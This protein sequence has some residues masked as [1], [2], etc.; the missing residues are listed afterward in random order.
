MIGFVLPLLGIGQTKNVVTTHRVFP[1]IDK[2]QEFEKALSAHSKKYHSGDFS[3]RVYEIQSGP[4]IGGFQITEGPN[5][6]EGLDSRGNLGEE[7]TMDWNKNIAVYLTDRQSV[8]YSVY[9]ESLSTVALGDF[10]DKI[11]ITHVYPKI[12][13]FLKV[14]STIQRLK[15]AWAAEGATVAVYTTNASGPSQF[16]LV[17]RYKQGLKEKAEGF[18]KPFIGIYEGIYG[19]G[20]YS[21][22]LNDTYM[23]SS[24]VWSELLF[25]RKDLGSK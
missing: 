5:S 9:D 16:A 14:K 25:F 23:Y 6:W 3:W 7:H 19:D 11:Q 24:D 8:T 1:K 10:S 4:D 15:A 2:V 22:F 13:M 17:T 20:S 12:G 18:H 21:E